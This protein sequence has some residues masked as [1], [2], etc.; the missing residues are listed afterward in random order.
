MAPEKKAAIRRL[1]IWTPVSYG[2]LFGGLAWM[3]Y[4]RIHWPGSRGL[5]L[6]VS[7]MLIGVMVGSAGSLSVVRAFEAGRRFMGL[8][9]STLYI[10]GIAL[11]VLSALIFLVAGVAQPAQ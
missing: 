10:V 7:G 3:L 8:R 9:Y 5:L 2:A 4:A 6:G 11:V 1:M